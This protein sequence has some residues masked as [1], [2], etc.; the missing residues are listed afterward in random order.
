MAQATPTLKPNLAARLRP[1]WARVE[2]PVYR[3]ESGRQAASPILRVLQQ[4][5]LP[6]VLAAA[7]LAAT[8]VAV[9][10]LPRQLMWNFGGAAGSGLSMLMFVLV[11]I[12]LIAG[13]AANILTVAQTAPL[14]SGELELQSW[15]LLRTTTLSLREIVF[16]KY[17]AALTHLR[18][19]LFG[20]LTLR[21]ASTITGLLVAGYSLYQSW[22]FGPPG[23][24]E[25]WTTGGTWIMP[26]IAL[27]L[28]VVWYA[29]QPVVQYL[30]SG[31]LG[32][33][34]STRFRSRGGAIAMALVAR[35]AL[36]VSSALLNIGLIYLLVWLL[37][38]N[39]ADP[40][41]APLQAFR[42]ITPP[43]PQRVTI[44][45]GTMAAVYILTLIAV[46][47]GLTFG[48]LRLA[49]RRAGEIGA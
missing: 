29:S 30:L 35:L 45:L 21:A 3:L 22:N 7:G 43:T 28:G 46:Q 20:L 24:F 17:A 15:G 9:F 38:E 49:E 13:A 10:T 14:I 11:L 19:A 26:A 39:W 2:N 36:W 48:A 34:V 42:S 44:V 31:A 12:Q 18:G 23:R 27:L 47:I 25:M 1:D 5:C 32:L 40:L 16:A 41:N 33:L 8:G 4:G 37:V 6:V